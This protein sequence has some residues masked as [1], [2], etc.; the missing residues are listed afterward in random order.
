[1]IFLSF[2]DGSFINYNTVIKN[3]MYS[4]HTIFFTNDKQ[5]PSHLRETDTFQKNVINKALMCRQL[6]L[7]FFMLAVPMPSLL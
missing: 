6:H 2:N 5:C 7:Q 1:M 3:Y 4:N